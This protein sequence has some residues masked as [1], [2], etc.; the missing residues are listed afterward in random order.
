MKLNTSK[1]PASLAEV[2]CPA[3]GNKGQFTVPKQ[4]SGLLKTYLGPVEDE[5]GL[6]ISTPRNCARNLHQF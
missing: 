4:F 2:N 1:K 6:G 3:C 5:S